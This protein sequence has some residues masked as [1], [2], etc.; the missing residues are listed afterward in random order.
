MVSRGRHDVPS[1]D[2][3]IE[4]AISVYSNYRLLRSFLPHIYSLQRFHD[5]AVDDGIDLYVAAVGFF[6]EI[7][8]VG[9]L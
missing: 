3:G 2:R 8:G 4:E 9:H 7:E 5:G 6:A 1:A